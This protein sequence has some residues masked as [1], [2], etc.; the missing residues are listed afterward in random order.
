MGHRLLACGA[1]SQDGC[2]VNQR[3]L[4][5]TFDDE[6]EAHEVVHRRRRSPAA[7]RSRANSCRGRLALVVIDMNVGHGIQKSRAAN[8]M[9]VSSCQ[10]A[11][12]TPAFYARDTA[13]AR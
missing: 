4:A 2:G 5:R 6:N 11:N 9:V 7:A 1:S 3:H 8:A 10:S 13:A 12:L